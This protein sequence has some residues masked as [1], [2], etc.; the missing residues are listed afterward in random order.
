MQVGTRAVVAHGEQPHGEPVVMV[1]PD[2]VG[3]VVVGN[4]AVA[5]EGEVAYG[6]AVN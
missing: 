5:G 1:A 6:Q 4:N 3:F 2:Q